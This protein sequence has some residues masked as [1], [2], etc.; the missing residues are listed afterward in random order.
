MKRTLP[1]I[2]LTLLTMTGCRYSFEIDDIGY[3]SRLCVRSFVCA[4]SS[5]SVTVH[6][7]IPITDA[8]NTDTSR[9]SPMF[10]LKCNG[11]EV[12]G[13]QSDIDRG[14]VQYNMEAFE[15]GDILELSV[16]DEGMDRVTASTVIPD[17]FPE[18][19]T[20]FS[21]LD[22]WNRSVSIKY[23]DNPESDDFYGAVVMS[24]TTNVETG[25]EWSG[26]YHPVGGYDSINIDY[27]A[28]SPIVTQLDGEH[29]F[30]WKDTDEEDNEYEIK[31]I[32]DGMFGE[33]YRKFI[34]LKLFK[35]SEEMYRTLCAWYDQDYNIFTYIG[36]FSPS[37]CYTNINNGVGYFGSYS[38]RY[39]EPVEITNE[40]K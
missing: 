18:C 36:F 33:K 40:I 16:E 28:Y 24:T 32:L 22:Q 17:F 13:S 20:E 38:I 15:P 31:Y 30:I 23:E 19:T 7:A 39:T 10:S 14:G 3:E 25:H 1:I 12:E 5:A 8:S 11:S 9:I 26:S 37:A 6:R 4:D 34:Y 21:T 29:L 27:S 2:I 35:M